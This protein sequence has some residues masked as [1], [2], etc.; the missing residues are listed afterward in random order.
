MIPNGELI[1][2]KLTDAAT[3]KELAEITEALDEAFNEHQVPISWITTV[4]NLL[5]RYKLLTKHDY[6]IY[7]EDSIV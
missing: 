6:E 5:E 7:K 2:G 3:T 4:Y 1:P